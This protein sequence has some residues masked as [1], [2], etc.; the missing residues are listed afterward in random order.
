M[1]ARS[2]GIITLHLSTWSVSSS[3]LICI[4]WIS[5]LIRSSSDMVNS[6]KLIHMKETKKIRHTKIWPTALLLLVHI[7]T[8]I[9]NLHSVWITIWPRYITYYRQVISPIDH[10]G[11][12]WQSLS[13]RVCKAYSSKHYES[14]VWSNVL[15]TG[16][17]Q[18][19]WTTPHCTFM[20]IFAVYRFTLPPF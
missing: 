5:D 9:K 4:L 20:F 3:P 11:S 14:K 7:S 19:P 13:L 18:L 16:P 8:V 17:Q 1:I 2:L 15:T 10:C 12:Q 6:S